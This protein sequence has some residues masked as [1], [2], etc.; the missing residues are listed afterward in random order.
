MGAFICRLAD[1][2]VD[3]GRE[4]VKLVA[5]GTVYLINI[6]ASAKCKEECKNGNA[7][8]QCKQDFLAI[9][10]CDECGNPIAKCLDPDK[11]CDDRRRMLD[12]NNFENVI[13]CY[14]NEACADVLSGYGYDGIGNIQS[15]TDRCDEFGES[16]T[17]EVFGLFE[18]AVEEIRVNSPT[19]PADKCNEFYE[20]S[21][22]GVTRTF[23]EAEDFC[24]ETFHSHLATIETKEQYDCALS[25]I[26]DGSRPWV[27]LDSWSDS[28]NTR[29][30]YLFDIEHINC[31]KP[32]PSSVLC[33]YEN[34]V[35][36][37]DEMNFAAMSELNRVDYNS[38]G[39]FASYN[40]D[41]TASIMII[42]AFIGL[43]LFLL[44]T[45]VFGCYY[46]V[47]S[48]RFLTKVKETEVYNQVEIVDK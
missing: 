32:V 44:I 41:S 19:S 1:K 33:N 25:T 17:G 16:C 28:Q 48:K 29:S 15:T 34:S 2:L 21:D 36:I 27:A 22:D 38:H 5:K 45:Y 30:E 47:C 6:F 13:T 39:I 46:C 20:Y 23:D 7:E 9:C 26:G 12:E 4:Y 37:T 11:I 18:S 10:K 24:E 31:S 3:D 14:N 43:I 8:K 35:C 42:I 40:H